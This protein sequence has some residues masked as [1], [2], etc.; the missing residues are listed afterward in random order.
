MN[1]NVIIKNQ[2]SYLILYIGRGQPYN[3]Q[4]PFDTMATNNYKFIS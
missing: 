1:I 3:A 4:Y 2:F